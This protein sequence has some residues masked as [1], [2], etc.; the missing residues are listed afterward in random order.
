MSVISAPETITVTD[1]EF[2]F[3]GGTKLAH[4]IGP[5]DTFR[6]LPDRYILAWV[7]VSETAEIFKTNILQKGTRVRVVSVTDETAVERIVREI[8]EKEAKAQ[9]VTAKAAAPSPQG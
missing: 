7:E 6:E 5:K 3:L 9:G 1:Y 4:T 2:I 8:R